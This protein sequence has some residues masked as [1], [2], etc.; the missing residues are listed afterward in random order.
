MTAAFPP[1]PVG[2]AAYFFFTGITLYLLIFSRGTD[3]RGRLI[4]FMCATVSFVLGITPQSYVWLDTNGTVV[5]AA[6]LIPEF[7]AFNPLAGNI[8]IVFLF[9][10]I[11]LIISIAFMIEWALDYWG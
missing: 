10:L 9:N 7:S 1:L 6:T 3:L 8:G 11:L 4:G 5:S 2:V